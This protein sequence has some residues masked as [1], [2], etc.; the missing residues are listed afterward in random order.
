MLSG[1]WNLLKENHAE[2]GELQNIVTEKRDLSRQ[3]LLVLGQSEDWYTGKQISRQH[4]SRGNEK[5]SVIDTDNTE[6]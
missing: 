6:M 1:K 3:R 4:P 2:I 5:K